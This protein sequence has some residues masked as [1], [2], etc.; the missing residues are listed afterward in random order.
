MTYTL[1]GIG[2]RATFYTLTNGAAAGEPSA[3]RV[4][5]SKNGRTWE[6]ID[7]RTGQA[8]AWRTQT[9]PFKIA[10]PGTYT[11]YRLVVTASTGTPT[12]SEVEFLTDGSKAQNTGLKVSASS[13]LEGIEGTPISGT[14]GTFSG[15][16]GIGGRRL[17]RHDRVG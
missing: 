11:A 8:F 2:Q 9:R 4:E 3:W 5:G 13:A 10:E 1:S 15:G 12:L 14:V 16:K 6:T 7:S 17:H